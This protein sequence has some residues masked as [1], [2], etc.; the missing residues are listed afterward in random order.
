MLS[1]A[2]RLERLVGDLL[3]LARLGAQDF[4]VELTMVDLADIARSAAAVW[5]SRCA[6]AEVAFGFEWDGV[7]IAAYSD[8]TRVRQVIDGLLENALRMTPAGGVIV[9]AV[10]REPTSGCLEVRDAGP[11]LTDDDI[12]VAFQRS[13]LYRRYQ[14]V[15][16]VGTGLG[17]T[18]VHGLTTRLGGTVE[19]GHAHDGG[20][21]FTVRLP[22]APG[23]L[24]TSI[25]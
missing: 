17:L 22:L 2:R 10:R 24:L 13:E 8:P 16:Q 5:H 3:D 15:R 25:T 19:A 11:G 14:A 18:I 4:R 1:E 12:A 6:A 9:L 23:Q 20:A 21:R 7:P